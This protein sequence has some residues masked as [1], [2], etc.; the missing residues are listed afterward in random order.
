MAF[1]GSLPYD[2][3]RIDGSGKL[4]PLN[5]GGKE[6]YNAALPSVTLQCS[7]CD[8]LQGNKSGAQYTGVLHAGRLA[9][10]DSPLGVPLAGELERALLVKHCM[11][12]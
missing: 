11:K 5:V 2:V 8:R 7:W 10:M 3:C 4:E 12:V 9:C 1:C 6:K